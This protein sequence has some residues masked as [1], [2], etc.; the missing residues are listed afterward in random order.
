MKSCLVGTLEF[1]TVKRSLLKVTETAS[2]LPGWN[3][4]CTV[5]VHEAQ[6]WVTSWVCPPMRIMG[7]W[8]ERSW[9][10]CNRRWER[11]LALLTSPR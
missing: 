2:A 6:Y 9:I 11:E 5:V 8:P 3:T 1:R 10:F 7:G 4:F